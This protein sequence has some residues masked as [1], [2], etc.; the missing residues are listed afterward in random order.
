M[1][2]KWLKPITTRRYI[3]CPKAERIRQRS[4]SQMI[5]I[6]PI[7]RLKNMQPTAERWILSERSL[8]PCCPR[9]SQ[10]NTRFHMIMCCCLHGW[11]GIPF[12]PWRIGWKRK[13]TAQPLFL[14]AYPGKKSVDACRRT[15]SHPYNHR[16]RLCPSM[17]LMRR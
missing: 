5:I 6:C 11:T 15:M 9:F 17:T 3:H 12:K 10:A 7:P 16:L 13:K 2:S 1:E 8:H 14:S 4:A